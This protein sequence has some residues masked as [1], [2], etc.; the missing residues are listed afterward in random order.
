MSS[1]ENPDEGSP[2]D[3]LLYEELIQ[4]I[5]TEWNLDDCRQE[6]LDAARYDDIDAVR[7]I[8]QCHP[9][10]ISFQDEH[11]GN[12]AL[13][14][15]AANGHETVVTLLL[16]LG[17][18]VRLENKAGNSPL[19]WA[20]S[21]GKQN[22]VQILLKESEVDVLQRNRFGRSAL[23]EGFTSENTEVVKA[24]LEH[25]SATEE[26][27]LATAGGGKTNE[28][29]S[30]VTH[31][32]QFGNN[33]KFQVRELAIAQSSEDTILGQENPE[34]DTTGLGI[35]ATS[36]ICARWMV[37]WFQ[38]NANNGG[39][40]EY[41]YVMELG[42]GCGVPGLAVATMGV[43]SRVYLTDFNA[44]TVMNLSHNVEA[45]GL[46]NVEVLNMNWQDR[47][48]WP[49][50]KMD[51]V[52]GSDLIYQ[53]DMAPLLAA[54]LQRLV[55][56][57][58]RFLYAAP[59]EGRQGHAEF[60]AL[61]EKSGFQLLRETEAPTSYLENPL[62]NQDDEDFYLH[63][64]ELQNGDNMNYKLHEFLQTSS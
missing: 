31:A 14:M 16:S 46:K 37:E 13:H 15:A 40:K 32:L 6:L 41:K 10:L 45:N 49:E 35:W 19:H 12:S 2:E 56:K 47:S 33:V 21:N 9:D 57:D 55:A 51:V 26:R 5:E 61:M 11:T 63:F 53:S 28:N 42:A 23:T 4:Q 8:L 18:S 62:E 3:A 64:N 22:I 48:T 17:A 29:N 1:H 50:E 54:T 58:G 44:R 24:L 7:A 36:L 25:E 59:N 27:L 34:D 20:A 38:T 52:I 30:S 43:S 39:D 60:L